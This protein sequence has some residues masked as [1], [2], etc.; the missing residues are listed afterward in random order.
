MNSSR[1]VL[2]LATLVSLTLA[3]AASAQSGSGRGRGGNY[4]PATETTLSGQVTKAEEVLPAGRSGRRGLGGLHLELKTG[5][6]TVVVHLGPAAF[7]KENGFNV[8]VGDRLEITGSRVTVDGDAV[9]L[10]REIKKDDRTLTLRDASGRPL[11][12]G[13][14]RR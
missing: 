14:R 1:R 3:P 9:L 10:A 6:A 11:W 13:G 5:D 8:A 4:D 7:V 12:S 2:I